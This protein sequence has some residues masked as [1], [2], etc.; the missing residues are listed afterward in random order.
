MILLIISAIFFLIAL[1][2]MAYGIAR[3]GW[4]NLYYVTIGL[5]IIAVV[6]GVIVYIN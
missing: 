5:G 2:T 4:N 1:G 6:L 3:Y